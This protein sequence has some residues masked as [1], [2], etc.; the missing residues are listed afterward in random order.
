MKTLLIS[1]LKA[2]CPAHTDSWRL[3]EKPNNGFESMTCGEGG[4]F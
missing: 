2:P 4:I 3:L 1:Q